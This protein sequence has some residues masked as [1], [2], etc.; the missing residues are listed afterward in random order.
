MAKQTD[1]AFADVLGKIAKTKPA[2]I[3]SFDAFAQ[4]FRKYVAQTEQW[5][6]R[7]AQAGVQAG[8]RD[9]SCEG[10]E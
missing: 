9:D 4:R 7:R 5:R 2:D 10:E 3:E 6:Q 8:L 1:P